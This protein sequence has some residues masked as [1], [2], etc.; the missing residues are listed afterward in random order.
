LS[1][2]S[3][4]AH[5][6]TALV[7]RA[8]ELARLHAFLGNATTQGAALL[9]PGDPGVGKTALLQAAGEAATARGALVLTASGVEFEADV[10]Y[11]TLNQLLLPLYDRDDALGLEPGDALPAALGLVEGPAPDR[12]TV[13]LATVGLLARTTATRPLVLIVDDLHWVDR[14]SAVVLGRVARSV[15]GS[16]MGFLAAYRSG[17]ESFFDAA[18]LVE[19]ELAPLEEDAAASLVRRCFP[20]LAPRVVHRVLAE[21]G[22]NPLA[23]VELPAALTGPQRSDRQHLPSMLPLSGRLQ[24]L[25]ATRVQGLPRAT[26]Y[27]LLVAALEGSGELGLLGAA[28]AEDLSADLLLSPAV[29][30]GLVR[31]DGP[32]R[33]LTFRHPLVR[34]TVVA[35]SDLHE[36]RAAHRAL[37]DAL[38]DVPER[39]AWHLAEATAGPDEEVAG[40]MEQTAYRLLRRGDAVGAVN[41]LLRAADLSQRPSDRSRRMAEG[42]YVGADV[43]GELRSASRLLLDAGRTDPHGGGSLRAAVAAS[44]VLLNGEGDIATAHRLLVGALETASAD[45]EAPPRAAL[46]EALQTLLFICLWGERQ[47]LWESFRAARGRLG[48]DPLLDLQAGMLGDPARAGGSALERLDAAIAGL[49]KETDP[50][51]IERIAQA[52]TFV[53]RVPACRQDL[54]RVVR[55]GR[56]GGAVTVALNALVQLS[57]DAFLTGRWDESSAMA[58]EGLRLCA[59]HG[60]GLL[61]WPFRHARAMVAAARGHHRRALAA[62]DEMTHWAAPRGVGAVEVMA[63]HIRT[64]VALGQSRFDEAFHHAAAVSPAGTLAPQ[65]A[66]ALWLVADLVE[67]AVHSGRRAEAATHVRAA[68]DAGLADL[69]PRL[70]LVVAGAAAMTAPDDRFVELFE[71]ALAGGD[72]AQWPFDV[73]RVHLSYGGRLRRARRTASSRVQLA[74]ALEIFQRLGAQPWVARAGAELRATGVP[75]PRAGR[76]GPSGLTPQEHQV[77]LLAASGLTN[78]EIAARLSISP[79]T[80]AAHLRQVFPKLD[81]TSRAALREALTRLAGNGAPRVAVPAHSS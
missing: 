13:A 8:G 18:H 40:L 70:A 68:Q 49:G 31:H 77:A 30:A 44:Y 11:S 36:R 16:R 55:D 75:G 54:W 7:G 21:A 23:L 71:A 25:F 35:T 67:A 76:T 39:R 46:A 17:A 80:V 62:A 73:A 81:I 26:R 10:A 22:G 58:E 52:G 3:A 48:E 38:R 79:R 56:D 66:H 51:R 72:V 41:A 14:A 12:E 15:T 78:R 27:L 9:M 42:A 64:V 61:E 50:T 24:G 63:H 60:Y 1:L 29:D 33:R 20:T 2:A 47:E 6:V 37:A 32:D 53:D 57:V 19:N 45:G 34:S 5:I 4:R 28:V 59:A 69:S 43:A 74:A 65:V